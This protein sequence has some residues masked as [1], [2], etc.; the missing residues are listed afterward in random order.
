MKKGRK[1]ADEL[2]AGV[3][4]TNGGEIKYGSDGK[5]IYLNDTERAYRSGYLDA[6]S[7]SARA[8]NHKH[9]VKNKSRSRR[10]KK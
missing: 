1:A 6:R 10:R 3:K 7:D 8:Y 9:G 2:K 4:T 5:P